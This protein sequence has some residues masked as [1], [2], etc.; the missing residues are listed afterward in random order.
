MVLLQTVLCLVLATGDD[1]SVEV[2]NRDVT[3]W[4]RENDDSGLREVKA[5]MVVEASPA[6]VWSVL[7]D[8]EKH[9]AFMPRLLESRIVDRED[10][11]AVFLYQRIS[12][13][14][15]SDRD[16]TVRVM[17]KVDTVSGTYKQ[18]WTTANH[19][20]PEKGDAIRL[21]RVEGSW[22][23]EP[24]ANGG[25]VITYWVHT[26]PGGSLPRF[27]VNAANRKGI[28]DLMKALRT[29]VTQY[30]SAH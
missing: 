15:V 17:S 8:V 30:A 2:D 7:A 23:L 11:G 20:G 1:W 6:S 22:T 29:R 18:T 24:G 16:F 14:L 26:S 25:T 27:V 9:T 19:R 10:D 28:P 13:P 21:A 3:V 5:R 4:S 12:P